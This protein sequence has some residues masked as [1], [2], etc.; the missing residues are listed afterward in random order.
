MTTTL[1]RNNRNSNKYIEV[2]HYADG[3]YAWRQIMVFANGVT[4]YIGSRTG[5]FFRASKNTIQDVVTA[6]YSTVAANEI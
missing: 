1:Y 2:K 6:D 4:N 3:H 5:R